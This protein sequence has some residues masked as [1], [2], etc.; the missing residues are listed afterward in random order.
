MH[1]IIGLVL[2]SLL[3]TT[4]LAHSG[5][6]PARELAKKRSYLLQYQADYLALTSTSEKLSSLN[7]Q[8]TTLHSTLLL[9]RN[10]L[11]KDGLAIPSNSSRYDVDYMEVMTDSLEDMG[12]TLQQLE[13][14][15]D[16]AE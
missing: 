6:D 14:A 8:L 12:T 11:A 9:L 7:N 3:A 1:T 2:A 10:T 5:A 16:A 13:A 15:I 4:A